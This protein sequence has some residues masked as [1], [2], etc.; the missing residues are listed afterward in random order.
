MDIFI[1]PESP[2]MNAIPPYKLLQRTMNLIFTIS[3]VNGSKSGGKEFKHMCNF[4]SLNKE[5]K[6]AQ[7]EH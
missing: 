6:G 4:Q 3:I 1:R 5:V 7:N 2:D